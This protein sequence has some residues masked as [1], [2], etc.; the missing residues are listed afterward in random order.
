MAQATVRNRSYIRK[1]LLITH[2]VGLV[3]GALFP[4]L[5]LPL[6]GP[7]A[8]T[9]PFFLLCLAMGWGV[10]ALIFLVVNATLKSQLRRQIAL[11]RPLAGEIAVSGDSPEQ[12]QEA[13]ELSVSQVEAF[14]REL[15]S[16]LDELIPHHRSLSELS[17]YMS[18]RAQEGLA[19]ARTTRQDIE[20]I[21]EKQDGVLAQV[22]NLSERSQDEAALSRELSASLEEMA[23]A[24][25]HSTGQFLETTNTVDEMASSIREVALQADEIALSVESTAHDLDAIGD[26]L[27]K[28]RGG[29]YDSA[30]EAETV[31][32]DA[33]EGFAVVQSAIEEME[34]IEEE[35]L[36]ATEAMERLSF[37]TGEVAKIIQVIRELV[38]DTE[39]LAFNA[40]IIAAKA[41]EDGKGFSVVAD[42]IRDLA[43]RTTAS[44]QDIHRIVK[45]IGGD[46]QE[47]TEAVAATGRRIGKGKQLSLSTGEALRK[48]AASSSQAARTSEEIAILTREQGERARALLNDAGS[49][50]RSVQSIARAM[51]EQG[52]GITRIQEGVTQM[53]A[54][55]DQIAR[56]MEEQ[57]RANRQFD[58][59]LSE[60]E[61][62]VQTIFEATQFWKITA[63]KVFSHFA[64]S[65][66]RLTKNAEKAAFLTREVAT[67]EKLADKLK[68]KA[69]VFERPESESAREAASVAAFQE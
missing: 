45:A 10:G 69:E 13:V 31:R 53:K 16:T 15:F 33:D 29:A 8:L 37:Q 49:S 32:K 6:L 52:T 42:E 11:L 21:E 40:A 62:Q 12:L 2:L 64:T 41:G 59:G 50:L 44:A 67:L 19:A 24:M 47:V 5:T 58:K 36:K 1:L 9:L 43:D 46:T 34:R 20:A 48:I 30:Q 54:A 68:D 27:E 25:E 63:Q 28:I 4:F 3:A 7:A 38:S 56:G 57:V 18:D 51:Q 23:D 35:S 60:R 14:I 55:S 61:T 65:E 22:E 66:V 17:R 26:S 39:L